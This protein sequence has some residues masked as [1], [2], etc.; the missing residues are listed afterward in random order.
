MTIYAKKVSDIILLAAV[1]KKDFFNTS[2][3]LI[4]L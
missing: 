2:A 1:S 3:P 4:A